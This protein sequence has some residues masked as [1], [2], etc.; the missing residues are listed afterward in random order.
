MNRYQFSHFKFATQLALI[1]AATAVTVGVLLAMILSYNL[2]TITRMANDSLHTIK[3]ELEESGDS[4]GNNMD[5]NV[6]NATNV[7]AEVVTKQTEILMEYVAHTAAEMVRADI[8][9]T[10]AAAR[11][12]TGA[13][14]GYKTGMPEDQLDRQNVLLLISGIV[15]QNPEFRGVWIGFE[16]NAFDGKDDEFKNKAEYGCDEAGR[17]VPW[18][19]AEKGEIGIE[20]LEELET[21]SYYEV[22]KRTKQEHITDPYFYQGIQLLTVSVPIIIDGNLIGVAGIDLSITH[23]DDLLKNYKPL[24]TG[25]IALHTNDGRFVWHPNPEMV[26]K[27]RNI[28]DIPGHDKFAQA[29]KQGQQYWELSKSVQ[30]GVELYK[31][32][33]PITFGQGSEPWAIL[34]GVDSAQAFAVLTK[35][36][37]E[38]NTLKQNVAQAVDSLQETIERTDD[39]ARQ[40]IASERKRGIQVTLI[41]S[42]CLFLAVMIASI[43]VGRSFARPMAQGAGILRVVA[44]QGDITV[45]VP[46]HL[47]QRGDEIGDVG[48][49]IKQILTDYLAITDR[50]EHLSNGDWTDMVRIKGEKDVLNR[51]FLSMYK[52]VNKTLGDI[53]ISAVQVSKGADE[54]S[55]AA[56]NL[57]DGTQRAVAS[58]EQ[59]TAS[60]GEISGQTKKTAES[61]GQARDLAQQTSK[62]ASEGQEAMHE[63]TQA[64]DRIMNNSKE[65]QRVI[66][67][68]DD[69]A[70][71][72]NLLALN[73]AVEAA[74]A[75]QHGK[76][77]AV[78]AEEVRN[79]ASRSAKAAGET[80]D[81]IA[82]SG[83]EVEKGG[84]VAV[85][86]ARVLDTIVEQIKRTTDIVAEIAHASNEQAQGVNQIT[87][88]L[89]QIE[90]VTQQNTTVAEES[91]SAADQMS[92]MAASLQ[93]LV[94]QFKL[95]E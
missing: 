25:F 47:L 88:G 31:L 70:F 65:I 48:R 83:Q 78:V 69:I 84:E 27:E 7:V 19:Y 59:I 29:I 94:G 90:S 64:M 49:S 81:L 3:N 11:T 87:L 38:L 46:Q 2:Q 51:D 93:A 80:S 61:A 30:T 45:N 17:F 91:A 20:P 28:I 36:Q 39:D 71:Q 76:G 92:S 37:E 95:K 89:H 58:L 62:G 5:K 85:R 66:K 75:G 8:E 1:L 26:A 23:F 41:T 77:F 57:S 16:P 13:V 21:S 72:T 6:T 32:V 86:T 34:V 14:K 53:K 15:K 56:Q 22:A 4:I 12:L 18:V 67:V 24:G 43:L 33:Y 40:T 50:I 52:R 54:V 74:R 79:L 42:V 44:E 10:F 68:I 73:A 60:I 63:M 82:K 9:T 55:G 35:L